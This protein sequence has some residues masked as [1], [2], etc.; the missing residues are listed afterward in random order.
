MNTIA[1]SLD[2]GTKAKTNADFEANKGFWTSHG[3]LNIETLETLLTNTFPEYPWP[4][5]NNQR[6]ST[7]SR[8]IDFHT[9]FFSI[10]P[11]AQ[12][13][14][15]GYSLD[16]SPIENPMETM[17]ARRVRLLMINLAPISDSYYNGWN[18][19]VFR[20]FVLLAIPRVP[21]LH[22]IYYTCDADFAT[23][24]GIEADSFIFSVFGD[25]SKTYEVLSECDKATD[26]TKLNVGCWN[27]INGGKA[28]IYDP[29]TFAVFLYT[30]SQAMDEKNVVVTEKTRSAIVERIMNDRCTGLMN[31]VLGWTPRR[32]VT[33]RRSDEEKAE[34]SDFRK[35]I[36]LT[37]PSGYDVYEDGLEYEGETLLDGITTTTDKKAAKMLVLTPI[38]AIR[39]PEPWEPDTL[40]FQSLCRFALLCKEDK[41]TVPKTHMKRISKFVSAIAANEK[42]MPLWDDWVTVTGDALI[43]KN[44][45]Q[46]KIKE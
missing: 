24:A 39:P 2:I 6:V 3:V 46:L 13:F 9:K 18:R 37:N 11:I 33:G 44:I 4:V 19:E 42:Q 8:R 34:I 29:S 17:R 1:T 38:F 41:I 25:K 10:D 40:S 5:K 30:D 7:D 14:E 32:L 21:G 12:R 43:F 26:G 36:T 15:S 20:A 31:E 28:A 16:V 35:K 27:N 22:F 45:S 23:R